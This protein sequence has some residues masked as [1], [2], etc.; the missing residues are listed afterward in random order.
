MYNTS[1]LTFRKIAYFSLLLL[2]ISCGPAR[3]SIAIEEGWDLLGELKPDFVRDKD[4]IDVHS[5]YKFTEIRFKVEKHEIRLNSLSVIFQNGDK[6]SPSV[7]EVVPPDQYS[8]NI[9]IASDGKFINRIEF[10]FRTTGNV[11]KG[12]ANVLVFGKRYTG[13]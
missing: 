3:R 11:F 9:E 1:K 6:L 4:A 5:S 7:D 13:Y 2:L 12:R 10:K 8:R